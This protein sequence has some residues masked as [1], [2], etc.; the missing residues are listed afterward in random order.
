MTP[1]ATKTMNQRFFF[2]LFLL[3]ILGTA[4][5]SPQTASSSLKQNS[6]HL[7]RFDSESFLWF[8]ELIEEQVVLPQDLVQTHTLIAKPYGR[9]AGVELRPVSRKIQAIV[10][11]QK[12][13]LCTNYFLLTTDGSQVIDQRLI[14]E[15]CEWSPASAA[16]S[17]TRYNFLSADEVQIQTISEEGNGAELAVESAEAYVYQILDGG[18]IERC[19]TTH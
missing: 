15:I 9:Y 12:S 11:E 16:R 10:L 3:T 17:Y 14:S 13:A 8:L 2:F 4:C 1:I 19:I 18:K 5:R 6:S 7:S